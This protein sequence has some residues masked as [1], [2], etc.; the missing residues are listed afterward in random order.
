MKIV[1]RFFP[2]FIIIMMVLTFNISSVYS[3]ESGETVTILF[4]HDLHDHF[5]PF[6][7][8]KEEKT[9]TVGG[10]ARLYSAIKNER[11]KDPEL[12]LVDAGDY[13]MGTLFQTIY[14]SDAPGLRLMGQMGFDVTTFGNHE[15]DFRADG[16]ASSLRAAKD[17]GDDL[18]QIVASNLSFPVD[19]DG[20]LTPSL[21]NLKE[22]MNHYDVN[23]YTIIERSGIKIGVLGLMG[24]DA[25]SNAPMAEVV[26]DNMV[27]SAETTV[28]TLKNEENVDLIIAVSHAGTSDE[29]SKSE[30]EILAE[31][32]PEIDVIVSG[33]S[34][35]VLKEPILVN[36]TI[37]GS[38]GEYGEYLGTLTMSR[39]LNNGWTLDNYELISIDDQLPLEPSIA[40]SIENY[41]DIVQEKYLNHFNMEFDEVLAYSPFNFTPSPELYEKHA[42]DPLGNLIG[43]S[44]IHTIKENEGEDYEPI[45][46]AIVPVGNI[47]G[48][49]VE[50][51]ITVSDVF[52]VSSLGI[53]PD[54][55]SG[56]PL[57]EVYLTGKELKTVAEVDASITPLMPSVQLYISGLSYTFNPNRLIFNKVT[58]VSLQNTDGTTKEIDN[59]KLYRVIA[60]LYSGQM[61]PVVSEKSFGLLSVIP[62]TKDGTPITNYEKEIIYSKNESNQEM[63]EWFA[64]AKYFKS[65]DMKDGTPEVPAYYEQTQNRKIVDNNSN[66]FAIIKNPNKI[67]LTAYT[68]TIVFA[69]I[70]AFLIRFLVKRR[71]HKK[72]QL[73]KEQDQTR[74]S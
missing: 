13:A 26:F 23:E 15:F 41:Q 38:S 50:G 62:K 71:K 74:S 55:I 35:T 14:A 17:S 19:D 6:D 61:L 34:H 70:L 37:I 43:D 27:E 49:F 12:I 31:K 24:E 72:E 10:Y 48:S 1:Y 67:T 58:N 2:I 36:N 39:D 3:E 18:P 68:I 32:V 7:I 54:K 64:V 40:E 63:K 16:L 25:D 57:I 29:K 9:S 53:G 22:A 59:D 42:E 5:Y 56:Y 28:A 51:E 20:N 44:F 8:E 45:A 66:F 21:A 4:T 33:H 46:A 11:E 30:D 60:G 65:F 47:R 69:G 73:L 52:N